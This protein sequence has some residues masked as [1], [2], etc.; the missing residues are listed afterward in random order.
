MNSAEA[1]W[2]CSACGTMLTRERDG[3]WHCLSPKC[4]NCAVKKEDKKDTNPKDAIATN[5]LSLHLFPD[6]ARAY[7]A[8]AMTEGALKYEA[9]NFRR[10]GV[11]ASVYVDACARHMAKWLNGQEVDPITQVPE[12]ASALAC[13]AILIDGVE[14]KTL[15]DDRPPK[16]DLGNLL[17]AFEDK[18]RLLRET[19]KK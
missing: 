12:L 6:T 18:V 3:Y 5:R 13:I 4:V 17:L 14:T 11:K 2:P 10:A 15:K 8:L 7:G 19:L 9:Y 16:A 1:P